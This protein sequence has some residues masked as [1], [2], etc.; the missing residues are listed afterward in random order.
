MVTYSY[1]VTFGFENKIHYVT[2]QMKPLLIL[3]TNKII[4]KLR[5]AKFLVYF[6]KKKER[7]TWHVTKNCL[8]GADYQFMRL[9]N[10]ATCP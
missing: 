4:Y 10:K 2:F 6:G 8:N 1:P 9:K 7:E 5:T 3:G